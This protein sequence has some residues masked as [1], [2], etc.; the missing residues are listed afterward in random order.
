GSDTF[1]GNGANDGVVNTIRVE[2]AG[3]IVGLDGFANGV[4]VID[5]R[6]HANVEV[7]GT[8]GNDVLDFS[9]VRFSNVGAGFEVDAGNNND[10]ITTSNKDSVNYRGG[11][12]NDTFNISTG[13][14]ATFLYSGTNNGSDTFTGNGANDG[15]VN[16]IRVES[17]GTIVGLDG[18]ANGVDVIDVRSHANVEVQGT[19]GNDV[20]DFSEVR[21]SNVG[22]G[23]EV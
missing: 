21:F 3:T 9:E 10:T 7:Q 2:S 23:F 18:F 15:V 12:G 6:S 1:T 19:T 16:T 14:A 4:D 11:H 22:A 8:T 5:V 20:L 13:Q 17:A